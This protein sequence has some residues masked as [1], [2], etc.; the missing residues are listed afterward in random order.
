MAVKQGEILRRIMTEKDI[1]VSELARRLNLSRAAINNYSNTETFQH[2]V[3]ERLITS[4]DIT[5]EY[6]LNY[7]I[8]Q[9]N[10]NSYLSEPNISYTQKTVKKY[11]EDIIVSKRTFREVPII[12]RFAYASYSESWDDPE[13]Y[14]T[15]ETMPTSYLEDG[16]Y[17][18][19]EVKGDSMTRD[20]D[21]SINER[22]MVLGKELQRHHWAALQLRRAK[23]W[24][25]NHKEQGLMIKEIVKQDGN[26]I[27]CNSWNPLVAQFDVDLND[28]NQLF[29]IK[30]LRKNF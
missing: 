19:F 6:F 7:N 23:V 20:E 12:N 10:E 11:S 8:D 15:F 3:F 29:Y 2:D 24:I 14:E 4:L 26:I 21:P 25:I 22:D 27:V 9:N 5:P 28:V 13:F 1:S 16:N 30:E 17:L 18:W